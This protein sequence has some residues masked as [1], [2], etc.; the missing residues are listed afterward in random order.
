M[1]IVTCGKSEKRSLK[2]RYSRAICVLLKIQNYIIK[3]ETNKK[4]LNSTIYHEIAKGDI[5]HQLLDSLL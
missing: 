2:I 1:F 4:A 5:R 3:L